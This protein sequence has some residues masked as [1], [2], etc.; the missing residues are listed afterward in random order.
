[1]F[2]PLL[3][4]TTGIPLI[5][6]L[7][8]SKPEKLLGYSHWPQKSITMA[9]LMANHFEGLIVAWMMGHLRWESTEGD[10]YHLWGQT[11]LTSEVIKVQLGPHAK[12]I[13]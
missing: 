4:I 7:L 9:R 5:I 1:M 11:Q 2:P 10:R 8:N 3:K 6:F 13:E 12:P